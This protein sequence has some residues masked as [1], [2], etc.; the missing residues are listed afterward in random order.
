VRPAY[1]GGRYYGG[2]G[3]VPYKSGSKSPKA[4]IA[5]VFLG[6]AFLAFWPGVWLYGAHLY[7][8]PY[9]YNYYN[10]SSQRN[11]SKPVTCACDP[12]S[13]C[14]CDYEDTA[15]Y[16]Q[17]M[18]DLI[19]N[20]SYD[21]LNKTVVNVANVNGTST[22]LINGTLDN[23]TTAAGGTEDPNAAGGGL[24]AMLQHAGWW[25]AAAAVGAIVFT[26]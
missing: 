6:V 9:P 25:P 2:G 7:N 3:A 4:L 10:E 18:S 16:K 11:E 17:Y 20:G 26:I 21:A 12:Y 24:R 15:E 14:G 19:G 8:H 5:P 23:G 1:G 13:E 22:I